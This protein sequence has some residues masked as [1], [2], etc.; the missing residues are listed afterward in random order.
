MMA[1]PSEMVRLLAIPIENH[2]WQS[3][4]FG[5]AVACLTLLLRKNEARL[6]FGA[7]FLA[8]AKFLLP[9]ALLTQVGS[10]LG[11]HVASPASEQLH[12]SNRGCRA[13]VRT[14]FTRCERQPGV[15]GSALSRVTCLHRGPMDHRHSCGLGAVVSAVV[16][17]CPEARAS[18]S[19]GSRC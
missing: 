1:N 2:L 10:T 4:L 14:I 18:S 7:W 15:V 17:G 5:L 19:D 3:T 16:L 13:A 11:A 9:F 8:S 6:R 12:L